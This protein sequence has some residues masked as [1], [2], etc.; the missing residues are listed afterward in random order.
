MREQTELMKESIAAKTTSH[1]VSVERVIKQYDDILTKPVEDSVF[2]SPI[3]TKL[4]HVE[5]KY[6]C[7]QDSLN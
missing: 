7:A 5:G 1:A 2:Y 6:W 3:K 4:P